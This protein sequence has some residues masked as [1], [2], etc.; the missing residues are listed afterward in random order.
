M[1]K[2]KL[3]RDSHDIDVPAALDSL[4]NHTGQL[5][6]LAR[7][8]GQIDGVGRM[9]EQERYCID[10]L[11]QTTA[12]RAAIK[13]LEA[14]ILEKHMAHCVHDAMTARGDADQKIQ[15]LL[16]VFKKAV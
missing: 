10:I 13:S 14:A 15:E 8:R 4:P 6:R 16:E 12:I 2:Q 9:I 1:A 3:V 5:K 7:I 11:A